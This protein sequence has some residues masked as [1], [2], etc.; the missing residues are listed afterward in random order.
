MGLCSVN[1]L[2]A[3]ATTTK[4]TPCF[5]FNSNY[6]TCVPFLLSAVYVFAFQTMMW[7]QKRKRR[8]LEKFRRCFSCTCGQDC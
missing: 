2:V 7:Q 4:T 1:D 6:C 5:Q 3:T 8:D